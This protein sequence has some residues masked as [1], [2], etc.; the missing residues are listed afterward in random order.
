[1]PTAYLLDLYDTLV[2]ADWASWWGELRRITGATEDQL[3]T[4]YER[5]RLQRNRGG[6][7]SPDEEMRAILAA[8]EIDDK[9]GTLATTLLDAEASLGA[10]ITVFDDS[11]PTL[12]RLRAAGARTAIVSNCNRGTRIIVERLGLEAAVDA[13]V[14]SFEVR[15]NKPDPGIYRAALD[16][17]GATAAD[18]LFVDDQTSYC[19]GARALGIDTRLIVRSDAT[20]YEGFAPSTNGHI[21]IRSLAELP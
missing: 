8:G 19:D 6:F 21:A 16:D 2:S 13:V 15:V 5:T 18:A 10:R 4:A 11:M 1:M 20:P 3:A 9:D 12:A 14:L 17:L 7:E